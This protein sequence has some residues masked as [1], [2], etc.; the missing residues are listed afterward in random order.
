MTWAELAHYPL[1][2]LQPNTGASRAIERALNGTG[3]TLS[4]RCE[5]SHLSPQLSLVAMNLGVAAA[6]GLALLKRPD[7][8]LVARPLGRPEIKTELGVIQL[9]GRTL[10]PAASALVEIVRAVVRDSPLVRQDLV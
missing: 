8:E 5:V 3:I 6:P 7:L 2:K 9:R 1:I 4:S 10:S